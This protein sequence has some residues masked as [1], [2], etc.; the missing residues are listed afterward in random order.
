MI[1]IVSLQLNSIL[2]NRKLP[3]AI[4]ACCQDKGKIVFLQKYE[5]VQKIMSL[6]YLGREK[7]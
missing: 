6:S 2:L 4:H 5:K 1:K 7:L 3:V